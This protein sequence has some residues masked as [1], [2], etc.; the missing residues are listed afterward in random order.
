[1]N[2]Y[3]IVLLTVVVMAGCS[4]S[5]D[6]L[7][8]SPSG[9]AGSI[10]RF[11]SFGNYLYALDQNKIKV[12]DISDASS[13][14]LVNEIVTDYGLETITFYDG[15]IYI[16][17]RSSLY[18]LDIST[19]AEPY[20]VSKTDRVGGLAGGCDPVSVKGNYAFSTVKII[21]NA[22]GNVSVESRLL[23][24]DVTDKANPVQV[25]EQVLNIPNGLGYKENVLFVCDEGDDEVVLFDISVPE[26]VARI[27]SFPLTDP[28]DLIVDGNRMVVSTKT[29]F[30]F[31]DVA[32][33]HN[34]IARGQIQFQ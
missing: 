6:S 7:M 3:L 24:Y 21:E 26:Q 19:P 16:G 25:A 27:T 11:T 30:S 31:F 17:S 28:V 23:V 10:T 9:K 18:I 32:D 29:G 4:K 2:R 5:G 15:G 8:Q 1:M 20:I 12:Y 33:V 14:L 13:P 22:C 34:I